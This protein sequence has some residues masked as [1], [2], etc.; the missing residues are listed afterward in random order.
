M[1]GL[2]VSLGIRTDKLGTCGMIRDDPTSRNPSHC[3]A[4]PSGRLCRGPQR[5]TTGSARSKR[6]CARQGLATNQESPGCHF[7][8]MVRR[9]YGEQIVRKRLA[10]RSTRAGLPSSSMRVTLEIMTHSHSSE[11][12][13]QGSRQGP[14]KGMP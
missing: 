13:A 2:P 1:T 4:Q 14:F 6:R 10:R 9:S 5:P 7:N 12:A 8:L 11:R 3:P